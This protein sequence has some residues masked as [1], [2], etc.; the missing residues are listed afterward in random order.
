VRVWSLPQGECLASFTADAA[1][2]SL[3]LS[4]DD[5][6]IAVGDVAGRVHFLQLVGG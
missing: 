6:S 3:A 4:P 2:Q 1:L 5:S